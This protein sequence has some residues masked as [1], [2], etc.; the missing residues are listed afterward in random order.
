MLEV[1]DIGTT[2]AAPGRPALEVAEVVLASTVLT[3]RLLT[4]G[5]AIRS[6]ETPDARGRL[7]P[8]HL[9]L[10]TLA[11]YE[12]AARN[13]HLGGSIGR[14]ANRI[15]GARFSLDG[16][17]VVLEPNEG[18]NQLHGGRDGFDRRV[19]ELLAANGADDGGTARFRLV[20]PD[21]DQG[22]PGAVT[23]TATYAVAGDTLR[24]AYEAIAD[25]PTVVNLTN[26]GYWNLDGSATVDEHHLAL[27]A[28][29]VLPVDDA[30]VPS[31]PL[32]PVA[33]TVFDLRLRTR[34]GPA[35]ASHPPGFDHCFAV[36][37]P[38]GTLR[39]AAVLDAP[40]SGR[41]MALRTDQPGVQLYTGNNLRDP[42]RTHG[43]V[44][45]ETQCFPDT[46]NRPD[47]G[48][49]RLGPGERYANVTELRFG[50]GR[51]PGVDDVEW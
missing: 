41:W 27:A 50:T 12:D 24:I 29:L 13:P 19:W 47:L 37:G 46:P 43:S 14:Y 33:G 40:A 23:A 1:H 3:V 36:P 16:R 2:T 10:P 4:L 6:V 39:A 45:L 17:D 31:G 42:F 38:A 28:D 18:P 32:R 22:F 21:G 5:G 35:V 20:S 26:H 48:S 30:G 44:S 15:A 11:D 51:P 7:G 9:G 25:A 8:V 49:A 34:L